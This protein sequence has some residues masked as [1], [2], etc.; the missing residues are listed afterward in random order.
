MIA[1]ENH[2]ESPRPSIAYVDEI[3]DERDNFLTDAFDSELFENIFVLPPESNIED[4]INKLLDLHIDALV[5]DFN[6]SEAGPLSYNGEQ[7]VSAFLAAR[8]NFPCFIRTSYDELA[9][10]SSDD[11]NRVYSKNAAND[12]NA[13]RN[14]FN[15]IALQVEHHRRRS[16]EWQDELQSLLDK[17][18]AQRT[19]ADIERIIE[20]DSEIEAGI[21]K[22][23]AIPARIKKGL[24]DK[25]SELIE[26]TERLIAEIK[27]A[28]KK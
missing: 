3:E 21:G 20:L 24:F 10:K 9:L 11:V 26:E 15:R 2:D 25:E 19:A 16:N 13:G 5:T 28:L 1:N 23:M 7:L 8:S 12:R 14:L 6:L 22:D 18:P 4:L 17:E 27:L